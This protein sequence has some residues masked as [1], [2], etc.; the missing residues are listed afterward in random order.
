M[1]HKGTCISQNSVMPLNC[2]DI[3]HT[4]TY[5]TKPTTNTELELTRCGMNRIVRLPLRVI[6]VLTSAKAT[7]T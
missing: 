7:H 6:P 3:M 4:V 5:T 2:P 1:E